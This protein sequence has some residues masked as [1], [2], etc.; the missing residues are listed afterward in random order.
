MFYQ[1]CDTNEYVV[2]AKKAKAPK[3]SNVEYEVQDS[4]SDFSI[5]TLA[6]DLQCAAKSSQEQEEKGIVNY[7]V[8]ED[9]C[10]SEFHTDKVNNGVEEIPPYHPFSPPDEGDDGD[11]DIDKYLCLEGSESSKNSAV[12]AGD[13]VV[14]SDPVAFIKHDGNGKGLAHDDEDTSNS[15]ID[16][17]SK[18]AT[19]LFP[20]EC[21]ISATGGDAETSAKTVGIPDD[22]FFHA[23]ESIPG[24]ITYKV[25]EWGMPYGYETSLEK[26]SSLDFWATSGF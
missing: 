11:D 9:G 10:S 17:A 22:F 25:D 19:N 20:I 14:P 5:G 18:V 16:H 1:D 24:G 13:S 4:S 12:N 26:D 6:D 8:Y 2:Q 3:E 15:L 21:D 23:P 7:F